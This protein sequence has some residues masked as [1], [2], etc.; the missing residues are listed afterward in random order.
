MDFEGK[1]QMGN[2]QWEIELADSDRFH[3]PF[4]ISHLKFPVQ[5]PSIYLNP[6]DTGV[7]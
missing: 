6:T 1:F 7:Q 2:G 5:S 4:D 3:F